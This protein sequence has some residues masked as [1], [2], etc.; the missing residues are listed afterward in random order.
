MFIRRTD[1]GSSRGHG[2]RLRCA[3]LAS[4][5]VAF[6]ASMVAGRSLPRAGA[7]TKASMLSSTTLLSYAFAGPVGSPWDPSMFSLKSTP[8]PPAGATL[9]GIGGRMLTNVAGN[10][11]SS[12]RVV[13]LAD[14]TKVPSTSTDV[15]VDG[16]VTRSNGDLFWPRV[17]VRSSVPTPDRSNYH[18]TFSS[19]GWTLVKT[20]NGIATQLGPVQASVLPGVRYDFR[21]AAVGNVVQAKVW[22]H[23]TTEPPAWQLQVPDSQVSSGAVFLDV[24]GGDAV[25]ANDAVDWGPIAVLSFVAH[26]APLRVHAGGAAATDS[27]GAT[28]SADTGFD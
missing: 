24:L 5:I 4:L 16:S 21:I 2:R 8:R 11:S 1:Y 27:N 6:S 22:Q 7:V 13:E 9:S 3:L 10:Y 25:G 14:T 18:V 26:P 15:E 23:A 28:W 20:F 12:D 17:F 19:S